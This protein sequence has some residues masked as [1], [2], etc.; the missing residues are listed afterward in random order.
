[1]RRHLPRLL[2]VGFILMLGF[3]TGCKP[4]PLKTTFNKRMALNNKKLAAAA[5]N[6]RKAMEPLS[7][8]KDIDI[9]QAQSSYKSMENL[10]T[11]LK[12]KYEDTA[13]PY[14][15]DNSATLLDAYKEFLEAEE[16]I[17]RNHL[18]AALEIA[19]QSGQDRKERWRLILAEFDE[20]SAKEKSALS[21]LKTAQEAFA[22]EHN[23]KVDPR[24]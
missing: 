7:M 20:A 1:M 10:I 4:P 14:G 9:S 22:T 11:E 13:I 19:L 6:M 24:M 12:V 8:N 16:K 17:L 18:K 5:W 15:S 2:L 23:Y 3:D 21:K